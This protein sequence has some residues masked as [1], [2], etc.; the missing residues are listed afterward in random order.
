MAT[1]F[2]D[3]RIVDAPTTETPAGSAVVEAMLA[4]PGKPATGK[5]GPGKDPSPIVAKLR[6]LGKAML[7]PA[8][9]I[10]IFLGLRSEER[11]AGKGWSS[12]CRSRWA[13]DHSKKKKRKICMT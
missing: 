13:P 12:T 8:L 1:Q 4:R 10:A 3:D 7:A 5:A 11:R 9:G 2:A 6:D